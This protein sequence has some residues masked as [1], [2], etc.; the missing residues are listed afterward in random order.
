M[1]R[2]LLVPSPLLGPATWAPVAAHLV[3]E[4]YTAQ[5]V[6]LDDLAGAAG[7]DPVLVVPHSNAGLHVPY[8]SAGLDVRATVYVDAALPLAGG[9]TTRLAPLGF[10]DFLA[11]LAD[12]D[13]LLPPW[14]HWWDDLADLFPNEAVR[15]A[16]EAEQPRLPLTWFDREVE[17]PEDWAARPS[18]YLG[19]GE[20]YAE[21]LAFARA[22]G[23]PVRTLP[24]RHLHQLHDP[25]GVARELLALVAELLP[26]SGSTG[27]PPRRD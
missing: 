20:T 27:H 9:P 23:W 6:V 12:P 16:V 14:T 17:V 15:A 21:E 22:Q 25:A 11:G 26:R 1:E 10:R 7:D 24:G 4:G 13:G 3:G 18:A 8:L 19:F 2:L 5:V